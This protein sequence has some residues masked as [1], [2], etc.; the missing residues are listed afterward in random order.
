MRNSETNL[1]Q[2][3]RL[4]SSGHGGR[5]GRKVVQTNL[6]TP[7][8]LAGVKGM[9]RLQQAIDTEVCVC[10]H[11][12][13]TFHDKAAQ[14][15]VPAMQPTHCPFKS[16]GLLMPANYTAVM[17]HHQPPYMPVR[18]SQHTCGGKTP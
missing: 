14:A 3:S 15:A 12:G 10:V 1:A 17:G 6:G 16:S 5:L 13:L 4:Y 18:P 8:S 11:A 2:D 7:H 9:G